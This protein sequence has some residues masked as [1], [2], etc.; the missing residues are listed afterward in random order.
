MDVGGGH[1]TF[2]C[3]NDSQLRVWCDI[4]GS[5]DTCDRGLSGLINPH[6]TATF[7]ELAAKHFMQVA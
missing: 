3:G 5:V 4:A 2:G 7:I 6:E 1:R